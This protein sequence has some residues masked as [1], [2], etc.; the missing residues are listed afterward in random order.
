MLDELSRSI[1]SAVSQA[2]QRAVEDA[3]SR[4]PMFKF[5][6]PSSLMSLGSGLV[7]STPCAMAW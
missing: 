2:V 7:A 5:F 1:A 3:L 6:R 4:L